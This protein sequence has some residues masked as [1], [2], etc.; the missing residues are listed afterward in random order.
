MNCKKLFKKK[1]PRGKYFGWGCSSVGR[2]S[3]RHAADTI[4]IPQCGKGFFLPR[5]NIQCRLSHGVRTPLCAIVCIKI[6]AHVK[7]PVVQIRV[8]WT[9]E[10]F[11]YSAGTVGWV[12]RLRRSWL[13]P[14]KATRISQGRTPNGTKQSVWVLYICW[15]MYKINTVYMAFSSKCVWIMAKPMN[16]IRARSQD[17]LCLMLLCCMHV[18]QIFSARVNQRSTEHLNWLN[19]A[20]SSQTIQHCLKQ[21][22]A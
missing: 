7:D 14:G 20:A 19:K 3:D 15:D 1:S 22:N 5:V 13:S 10:T 12:A 9:M 4:S 17:L 21:P 6:C 11:A 16:H 8:R 2:A 18:Y